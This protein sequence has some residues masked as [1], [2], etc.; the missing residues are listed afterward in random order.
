MAK[1]IYEG[2]ILICMA[3]ILC[4]Y[5]LFHVKA[6]KTETIV[7]AEI[8]QIGTSKLIFKST[9]QLQS[10]VKAI[11]LRDNPELFKNIK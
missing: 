10:E 7:D 1:K 2:G 6:N 4:S 3:I 5:I 9:E 11:C 8:S